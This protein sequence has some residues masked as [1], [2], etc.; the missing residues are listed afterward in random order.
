M[1]QD[2]VLLLLVAQLVRV[3]ADVLEDVLELGAIGLFDGMQRL[4]DTLTV[5]SLETALVQGIERGALGR[6]KA[7]SCIMAS[8][9]SGASGYS[10]S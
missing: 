8:T 9:S 6:T 3:E 5:A 2:V 7:S 4:V 10:A 1:A